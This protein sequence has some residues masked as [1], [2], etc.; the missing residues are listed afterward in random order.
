MAAVSLTV[1]MAATRP[2][3][4][5]AAPPS[6]MCV[7][8][9]F[10]VGARAKGRAKVRVKVTVSRPDGSWALKAKKKVGKKM[11][12][13]SVVAQQPGTYVTTYKSKPK[14][15][16]FLTEVSSCGS[17][18]G[19]TGGGGGTLGT[20]DINDND[21]GAA[22]FSMANLAPGTSQASCITVSYQGSLPA[23]VRMYGT[24]TGS[25]LAGHLQL[26]VERGAGGGFGTCTGFSP[27]G[28]DYV[29]AGPGV[30][31]RG[32]LTGWP[33]DYAGGRVDPTS[34]SPEQWTTGES[35]SY[36]FTVTLPA[37]AAD[38]A[39]GLTAGQTFVWEARD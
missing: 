34:G 33:D 8:D 24:T 16:T 39:Q 9:P 21:A 35:H 12:S 28:T 4:A 19:G 22:M 7:G 30:V 17:G 3:V 31:Y 10:S 18:G 15:W 25:G 38:A 37:E 20:V 5:V 29:G 13:W 23:T 6:K 32:T 27:D 11:K 14:K 1:V 36:R 26:T 2:K